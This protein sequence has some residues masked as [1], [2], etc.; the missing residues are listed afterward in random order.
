MALSKLV[1][2]IQRSYAPLFR[3]AAARTLCIIPRPC[4]LVNDPLRVFKGHGSWPRPRRLRLA[5]IVDTQVLS[6]GLDLGIEGCSDEV[7]VSLL[8]VKLWLIYLT[9]NSLRGSV[10][11]SLFRGLR[12]FRHLL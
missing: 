2:Q 3:L 12:T 6:V 11:Q 9:V 7:H 10:S 8:L 5:F 1:G 4:L